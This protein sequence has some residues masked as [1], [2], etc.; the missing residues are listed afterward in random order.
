MVTMSLRSL[1]SISVTGTD[2]KRVMGATHIGRERGREGCSQYWRWG[3][4]SQGYKE[5][6]KGEGLRSIG[7]RLHTSLHPF[8]DPQHHSRRSKEKKKKKQTGIGKKDRPAI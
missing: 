7:E 3:I 2:E 6:G 5:T 1:Q 8:Q 4:V